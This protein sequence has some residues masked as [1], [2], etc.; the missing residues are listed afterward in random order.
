[1]VRPEAGLYEEWVSL[2]H[3]RQRGA[4]QQSQHELRLRHGTIRSLASLF[5]V[6]SPPTDSVMVS[7]RNNVL[8]T[9]K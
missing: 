1:M 6:N 9:F 4:D 5:N 2:A 8:S 3:H 7:I